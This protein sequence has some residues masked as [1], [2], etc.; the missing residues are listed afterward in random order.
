MFYGAFRISELVSPSRLRAGGLMQE[1]VWIAEDKVG[2]RLRRSKTDQRG[3]GVDVVLFSLPGARVC[4]VA[5]VKAFLGVRPEG[6]GPLLR[7]EDGSF[8]SKFQFVA[9]F[10]SCL[11]EM[12]LDKSEFSSHSFRIGAA[13]EAARCGMNEAA[14]RK[15]GRWESRRFR[16]Y[17]RPQLVVG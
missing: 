4:P 16:S 1:D 6:G 7:H 8:L 11:Q 13:T 5:A 14:V 15:I 10:R 17:V 12:G 9:V 3:R 2:I